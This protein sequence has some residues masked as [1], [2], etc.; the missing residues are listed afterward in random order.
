MKLDHIVVHIDNNEEL[1]TNLKRDI[2]PLGFPFEPKYGKGTSGFKA[3]N[4]WIG[5]QYF[6]II[7]LLNKSGG[8]WTPK[9]VKRYN[10][11]LRG[12]YCIFLVTDSIADVAKQLKA[13]GLPVSEP[14]RITFKA[15]FGLLKKT[16]PWQLI[17]LPVIPGT[18][19]ELGFIQY[20]PDP[21]DRIKQYLVPNSDENGISGIETAT[22][23][24]PLGPENRAF[25]K[26]VFPN[27]VDVGESFVVTLEP[28]GLSFVHDQSDVKVELFAKVNGPELRG[29]KFTLLNVSVET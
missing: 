16:L 7:R 24:L 14:E 13:G 29:R 5:R 11:G 27:G 4:I 28:G 25:L 22:I 17:Y 26:K 3:A 1:L 18:D 8:G 20:D 12:I 10:E 2:E 6:E 19:L 23:H 21:N 9:W 15:L